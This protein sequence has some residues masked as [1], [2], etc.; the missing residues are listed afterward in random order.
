MNNKLPLTTVDW[1]G[2]FNKQKI[3]YLVIAL[4]LAFF[5]SLTG[6]KILHRAQNE[7]EMVSV[8]IANKNIPRHEKFKLTDLE[9]RKIRR[10]Q[11]PNYTISQPKDAQGK[12][13][14]V[15]IPKNQI[16]T[17]TLFKEISNP[18]SLSAELTDDKMAIPVGFDC[19]A[20][21]VPD[22]KVWDT[23][24]I[25]ASE[26]HEVKKESGEKITISKS[27]FPVR[28]VRVLRIEKGGSYGKDGHLV[29]EV[30][31]EQANNLMATKALKVL[32]NVIVKQ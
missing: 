15:T 8:V 12:I 26:S 14:L 22:I 4:F 31:E 11:V 28:N 24:D 7:A 29:L 30:T 2:K 32:L 21:P 18:D 9:F 23:I 3:K 25:I 19:L 16:I 13:S 5:V 27:V 20:D 10:D 1:S 6:Y 17:S